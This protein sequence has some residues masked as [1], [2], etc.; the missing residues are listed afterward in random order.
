MNP[1]V[2]MI[3][4]I[5]AILFRF[6]GI[7]AFGFGAGWLVFQAYQ[8]GAWQVQIAALLGLLGTIV[9][10]ADFLTGAA[11]AL[12]AFGLGAGGA[13]I[14]FGLPRRAGGSGETEVKKK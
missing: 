3:I 12:G 8:K 5:L 10:L 4:D 7:L 6:I 9:G 11:G 2:Q 1:T 13:I 14:L